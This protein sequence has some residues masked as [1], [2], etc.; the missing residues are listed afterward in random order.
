M[1]FILHNYMVFNLS[2]S[3]MAIMYSTAEKM[4]HQNLF[5][6]PISFESTA[7]MGCLSV[8]LKT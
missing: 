3:I 8:S 1:K 4:M 7:G 5:K 2:N 6:F